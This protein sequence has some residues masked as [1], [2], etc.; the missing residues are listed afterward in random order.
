[1]SYTVVGMFPNNEDA[2]RASDK[3]SSGGFTQ[4]EYN[5]SNYRRDSDVEGDG[6]DYDEDESTSGF[7]GWL[8]GED[9]NTRK[10]YSRAGSKS[11]V[12]TVYADD[13][14]RAERAKQIMN[15]MGAV[16]V[17]D[18][19]KDSF[20]TGEEFVAPHTTDISEAERARIINKARNDN[21][22]A[23]AERSYT[24]RRRTGM[25]DPMDSQGDAIL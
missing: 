18:F 19:T 15:D 11:N 13:L 25:T 17:N 3:L 9:D 16:D 23:A 5:V 20:A 7:W 24:I 1:M 10:K 4:N 12:V 22:V 14:D 2:A 21:Y 8:F 6:Y